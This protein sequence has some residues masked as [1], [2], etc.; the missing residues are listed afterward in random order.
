MDIT[1]ATILVRNVVVVVDLPDGLLLG[2]LLWWGL[3]LLWLLSTHQLY[4][5]LMDITRATVHGV[6][7]CGCCRL[8]RCAVLMDITRATV[9][10][11]DVVVV[12]DSPD[13]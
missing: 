6:G 9:M 5:F 8:T 10:V 4:D 7:C 2:P 13:V 3:L 12:V 11:W 1:G